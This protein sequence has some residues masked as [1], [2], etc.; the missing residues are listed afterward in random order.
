[1]VI[2]LESSL[3]VFRIASIE[4]SGTITV[5]ELELVFVAASVAVAAGVSI[6]IASIA[7]ICN[8]I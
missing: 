4:F 5:V 2:A 7:T 1:M 6:S 3:S 8:Y